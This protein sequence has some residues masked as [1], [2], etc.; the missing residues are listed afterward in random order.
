M[1]NYTSK[2]WENKRNVILK[3]DGYKCVECNRRNITKPATMVHHI[4]PVD[5]YPE[6]FLDNNNL[7][8]LCD[9]CHNKMHDRKHKTLSKLGRKYQKLYYRKRDIG[10][11]TKIVFVV[12]APC[13]GKSTYVKEHMGK[14]DIVFDYDEISRAMTGCEIHDNNPFI[15]KYLNEFRKTFLRMLEV[16]TEFDTAYIITTKMSKYYYNYVLY[17]PEVIIMSTSKEECLRRLYSKPEGRDINEI[18]KVILA[19]YNEEE[20]LQSTPPP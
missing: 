6:L 1:S 13:S 15:K 12:G 9:E 11:M 19:Y 10:N 7:I 2:K 17:D 20:T 8:S 5:K 3:R 16:E 14:N 4:N 18:R